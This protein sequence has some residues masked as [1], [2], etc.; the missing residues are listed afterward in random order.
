MC[1]SSE[2]KENSV[3]GILYQESWTEE[4]LRKRYRF[5]RNGIDLITSLIRDDI[6]RDTKRNHALTAEQVLIA[7]RF[8]ASGSF[9]QMIV[10]TMGF[11][12]STVSLAI[13]SVTDSL[14]RKA[15]QF[16]RWLSHDKKQSIKHG[17]Y[18][19]G[20]FPNTIGCIDGTHI[21]I[22]AP[23]TADEVSY[24]NRKNFHSVN[25]QA[26]CD[27][28]SKNVYNIHNPNTLSSRVLDLLAL[29]VYFE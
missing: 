4:E 13:Q 18:R 21:R 8:Y 14:V 2:K 10:D 20:G 15:A 23:A 17:L 25:V 27:H 3:A 24:V 1:P 12:K 16:I 29:G 11:D 7:L 22:I 26:V 19:L 5:G 28:Q 6:E 9:M